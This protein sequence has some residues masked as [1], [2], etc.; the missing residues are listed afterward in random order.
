MSY[1][2]SQKQD[3][4]GVSPLRSRCQLQSDGKSKAEVLVNQFSSGFTRDDDTDLPAVSIHIH[5]SIQDI[6]ISEL[7]VLKLLLNIQT[8]KACGPDGISNLLLKGC[9]H[10]ITLVISRIFQ[11]SLDTD[12]PTVWS[13]TREIPSC[14]LDLCPHQTIGTLSSVTN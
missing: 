12:L 6:L 1:V 3:S 7:V 13:C 9:A 8:S 10:E 4:I 2:K 11:C 14:V 5:D